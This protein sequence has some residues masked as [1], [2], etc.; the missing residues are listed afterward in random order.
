MFVYFAKKNDQISYWIEDKF[1]QFRKF[2]FV[3]HYSLEHHG[4]NEFHIV[5]LIKAQYTI[6]I[7][8][9]FKFP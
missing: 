9:K 2:T 3:I 8:L 7:G 6:S 1:E 4:T 5:L